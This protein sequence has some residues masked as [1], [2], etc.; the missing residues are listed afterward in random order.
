MFGILHHL[1][2]IKTPQPVE[3]GSAFV[4][5]SNRERGKHPL[6]GPL[7]TESLNPSRLQFQY[8]FLEK[9]MI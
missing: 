4:C 3:D 7:E 9:D 5:M 6:G 1:R 8:T 2:L